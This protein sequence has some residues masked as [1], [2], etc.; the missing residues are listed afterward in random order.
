MVEAKRGLKAEMTS[1]VSDAVDEDAANKIRA[2]FGA[3]ERKI[4]TELDHTPLE[5]HLEMEGAYKCVAE[6]QTRSFMFPSP[7]PRRLDLQYNADFY[8]PFRISFSSAS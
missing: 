5:M 4:E 8:T 2:E 3:R 7:L 1:A 6:N